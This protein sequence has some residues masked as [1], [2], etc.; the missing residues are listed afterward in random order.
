MYVIIIILQS[1]EQFKIKNHDVNDA[2]KTYC[3]ITPPH[4]DR[5]IFC[6]LSI[7]S[8]SFEKKNEFNIKYS[9]MMES[10]DGKKYSVRVDYELR[11]LY[12][13]LLQLEFLSHYASYFGNIYLV[14]RKKLLLIYFLN[15]LLLKQILTLAF[16]ANT[17]IG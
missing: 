8:R 12:K 11:L 5:V 15:L 9:E 3:R 7:R 13:Y 16:V 6:D 14:S 4:G 1:W 10:E 17:Q 2:H